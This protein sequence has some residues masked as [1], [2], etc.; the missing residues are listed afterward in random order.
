MT[1]ARF[2]TTIFCDDV[3]QELGNKLSLMGIYGGDLYVASMPATLPKLC[4]IIKVV[5]PADD[6]FSKLTV[7]VL[8][9]DRTLL[10]QPIDVSHVSPAPA[11]VADL[12]D[13]D[14]SPVLNLN[15]I[16]QF[17]PFQ[18]SGPC[19][20]RVRVETEREV[21]KAGILQIAIAPSSSPSPKPN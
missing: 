9:D 8:Q 20:L 7:R 2:A 15:S 16:V 13:D 12:Q 1:M 6:P 10:E 5:T 21:L 18:A 4:L 11:L 14:L 3:R 19:L 17:S